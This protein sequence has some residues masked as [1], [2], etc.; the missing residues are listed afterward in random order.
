MIDYNYNYLTNQKCDIYI[1]SIRDIGNERNYLLNKFNFTAERPNLIEFPLA[2][3]SRKNANWFTA[4][5]WY[6]LT[7]NNLLSHLLN[8]KPFEV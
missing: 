1:S 3:M 5:N 6:D 2:K 7:V 8:S 4:K